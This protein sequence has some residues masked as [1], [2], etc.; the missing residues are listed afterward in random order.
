MSGASSKRKGDRAERAVRDYLKSLGLEVKRTRAGFNQDLGDIILTT[1]RGLITLQ[2]KD[3]AQANWKTWFEQL[4]SQVETLK[5]NTTQPVVGGVLVWKLR[6]T[7]TSKW[8]AI[9]QLENLQTLLGIDASTLDKED[10][11]NEN[12]DD[13]IQLPDIYEDQGL[14]GFSLVSPKACK[15]TLIKMPPDRNPVSWLE[16]NMDQIKDILPKS[17]N[18][19]VYGDEEYFKY[20][21]I[22]DRY[23]T[24]RVQWYQ[25]QGLVVD[26]KAGTY[27][28][29]KLDVLDKV[30]ASNY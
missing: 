9:S 2:V 1:N 12:M 11:G 21:S 17:V 15:Y 28:T 13:Y 30:F 10:Q 25:S 27:F 5:A 22:R 29:M 24:R 20:L 7:S 4:D 16:S 6:G 26:E 3:C 8:R 19:K 23:G 14:S 18:I